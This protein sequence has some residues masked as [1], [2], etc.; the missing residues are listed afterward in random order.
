MLCYA[1]LLFPAPPPAAFGSPYL[2]SAVCT[3]SYLCTIL[4]YLSHY[5]HTGEGVFTSLRCS[6]DCL[7]PFS[8]VFSDPEVGPMPSWYTFD[9][10]KSVGRH[11]G[12]RRCPHFRVSVVASFLALQ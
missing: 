4:L 7:Q 11:F 5:K 12:R 6:L 1:E 8:A 9:D 3:L 2:T 10:R